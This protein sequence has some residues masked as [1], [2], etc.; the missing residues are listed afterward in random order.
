VDDRVS[1]RLS[2]TARLN[3]SPLG[4]RDVMK[5]SF[6]LILLTVTLLVS[7]PAHACDVPS[8]L[9]HRTTLSEGDLTITLAIDRDTYQVGEA[10]TFHLG[11]LNEGSD[12]IS[13]SSGSDPMNIFS[14]MQDSCV[15]LYPDCLE[16]SLYFYPGVVYYFGETITI[17]PGECETR[18]ETWDGSTLIWDGSTYVKGLPDPGSFV[19]LAG[20]YQGVREEPHL[21]FVIPDNGITL[22]IVLSDIAGVQ[23]KRTTWGRVKGL[24]RKI[25]SNSSLLQH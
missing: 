15:S 1:R 16:A 18:T 13:V 8:N 24:Y 7:S 9:T 4:G 11:V 19:V 6:L 22:Q 12:T 14:V 21:D 5:T 23:T 3:A 20:L 25:P 2:R 10:V 17:L